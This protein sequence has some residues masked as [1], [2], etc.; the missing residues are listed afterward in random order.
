M[1]FEYVKIAE[2]LDHYFTYVAESL[3]IFKDQSLLSQSNEIKKPSERVIK[4]YENHPSIKKIKEHCE[5]NQFEFNPVTINDV[6]CKFK[7]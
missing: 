7:S 1:I 2:N 3:G 6:L 5:F 4:K